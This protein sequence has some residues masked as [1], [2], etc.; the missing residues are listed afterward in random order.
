MND[1][2]NH[3]DAVRQQ[4]SELESVRSDAFAS[5][6]PLQATDAP[7]A[8]VFES[9]AASKKF[10]LIEGIAEFPAYP[11]A[12]RFAPLKP[13]RSARLFRRYELPM[14]IASGF[15]PALAV[16]AA[17]DRPVFTGAFVET[18]LALLTAIMVSWYALRELRA[19]TS[20]GS[21]SYVLPVNF[22]VFTALTA[23]VALVRIPYSGSLLT[24]G[25]VGAVAGSFGAG[26][27]ARRIITPHLIIAGGRTNEIPIEGQYFVAPGAQQLDALIDSS[28]RDWAIVADLHYPHSEQYER[29]FAKAALLGIPVY[30]Y[31]T[32]AEAASGQVKVTHLSENEFGSLIPH[33]PYMA[34]KRLIDI[35]AALVL[36]PLCL[37]FFAFLALLICLDSPGN[38]FFIQDRIGYRGERF[39][40][41][42]FRTMRNRPEIASDI[43][44]RDDAMTKDDDDRITRIGR[45]LRKTR[46]DELP[47][48]FNVLRGEMSFI[49]PR[50]EACALSQWYQAELPFYSYRHIVR[51][52]ITGWAQV[53]QG[54][55]TD[56]S[57]VLSKLRFDFY[58]IKNISLW[59]DLLVAL[60]TF[61]VIVTGSGAK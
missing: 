28:W 17:F 36:I 10:D 1:L 9:S 4:P 6:M 7:G 13:G 26:L 39:R 32:V 19:H 23:I 51:P 38:P 5:A 24:A 22:A 47:Q 41:V 60:K 31:R 44:Q 55:V 42:K 14:L 15:V 58:Y 30:H 50:P 20:A 34:F 27:I 54:H 49:G 8:E 46:L 40:M 3:M 12:E 45:F 52:G 29:L 33:V 18:S 48:I 53:T 21:L 57:D 2:S 61:R 16:W 56:V 43:A 59:L 11:E 37:P 35:A 25:A